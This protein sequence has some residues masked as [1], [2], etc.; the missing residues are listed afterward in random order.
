MINKQTQFLEK[1]VVAE[2]SWNHLMNSIS[3]P[4]Y[5]GPN[6]NKDF[7]LFGDHWQL[8]GIDGAYYNNTLF[9]CEWF[10]IGNIEWL[11]ILIFHTIHISLQYSPKYWKILETTGNCF[12]YSLVPNTRGP[13][14][15][16]L[17]TSFCSLTIYEIPGKFPPSFFIR[18]SHI[19]S[20]LEKIII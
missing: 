20:L 8:F 17:P 19:Y 16:P 10:L 14:K 5:F 3:G 4:N 18:A 2:N 9:I 13:W 6:S 11:F 15:T 7:S 1:F 12:T